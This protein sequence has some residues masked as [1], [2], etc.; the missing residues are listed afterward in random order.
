MYPFLLTWASIQNVGRVINSAAVNS[1]KY[2]VN[3]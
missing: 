1:H 3:G 2:S